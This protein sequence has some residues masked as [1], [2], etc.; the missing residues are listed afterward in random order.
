MPLHKIAFFI[1]EG[2]N[3]HHFFKTSDMVESFCLLLDSAKGGAPE[4][5]F[6]GEV[7]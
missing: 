6:Y 4:G 1:V 7:F 5:H 3:D 2:Q